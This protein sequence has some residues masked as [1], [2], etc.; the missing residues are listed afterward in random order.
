MTNFEILAADE[1]YEFKV[2]HESHSFVHFIKG[3]HI[4]L[5]EN[6]SE[7]YGLGLLNLNH[8]VILPNVLRIA[9]RVHENLQLVQDERKGGEFLTARTR[10]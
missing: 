8:T 4:I 3:Y 6:I 1:V 9:M 5:E 7:N 10:D 2:S